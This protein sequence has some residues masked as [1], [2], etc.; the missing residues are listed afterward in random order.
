MDL[1]LEIIWNILKYCPY[2]SLCTLSETCTELNTIIDNTALVKTLCTRRCIDEQSN[3]H[4]MKQQTCT[5]KV[6]EILEQ[7]DLRL[8]DISL[9]KTELMFN[10]FIRRIYLKLRSRDMID[11]FQRVAKHMLFIHF[12]LNIKTNILR[13][14][15]F[16]ISRHY[17][18]KDLYRKYLLRFIRYAPM[19]A[20]IIY[21]HLTRDDIQNL[22]EYW[23]RMNQEYALK[24]K[25]INLESLIISQS[26]IQ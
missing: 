1:P 23:T 14:I 21:Q 12:P 24:Y 15:G 22:P 9:L 10:G 19:N 16:S 11:V 26:T 17:S 5:K 6:K 3:I 20:P 25:Q 8:I 4:M 7:Y 18:T 2:S 13:F